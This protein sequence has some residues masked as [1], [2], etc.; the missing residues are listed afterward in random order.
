VDRALRRNLRGDPPDTLPPAYLSRTIPRFGEPGGATPP[1]SLRGRGCDTGCPVHGRCPAR[2]PCGARHRA[3]AARLLSSCVAGVP[4]AC[5]APGCFSHPRKQAGPERAGAWH[6]VCL[7]LQHRH[8][9][10]RVT[11]SQRASAPMPRDHMH[12]DTQ[13]GWIAD[14]VDSDAVERLTGSPP[15]VPRAFASLRGRWISHRRSQLW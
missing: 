15:A 9:C 10:S 5:S 12:C 13:A 8:R 14:G 4:A 6:G 11:R 3:A 7:R 2:R 1:L